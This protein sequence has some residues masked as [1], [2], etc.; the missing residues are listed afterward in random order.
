[1][2]KSYGVGGWVGGGGWPMRLYCKLSRSSY[3]YCY[4]VDLGA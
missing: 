4:L 3:P 2:V 1:M